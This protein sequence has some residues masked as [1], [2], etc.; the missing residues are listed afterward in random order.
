MASNR[1]LDACSG[2]VCCE[3]HLC[4]NQPSFSE[5]AEVVRRTTALQ[6][7]PWAMPAGPMEEEPPK[8]KRPER[9]ENLSGPIQSS[10]RERH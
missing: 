2:H 6:T 1:L 8:Y 4:L 10:L 3:A 7:T 9:R 5:A